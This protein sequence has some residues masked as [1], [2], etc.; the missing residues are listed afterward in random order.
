MYKP[1]NLLYTGETDMGAYPKFTMSFSIGSSNKER[2]EAFELYQRAFKAKKILESTPP[3]NDD[4]RIMMEIYGQ[5]ILIGP[6][7]SMGTGFQGVLCCEVR[8]DKKED[9][10]EAYNEIG[11]EAQS[12]HTEGPYPWAAILGLVV[13]K[14]GIGWALYYNE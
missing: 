6:G 2:I 13:D 12:H 7:K 10:W 14:F 5:E 3:D 11:K 8:Y 1:E 9:F 4:I